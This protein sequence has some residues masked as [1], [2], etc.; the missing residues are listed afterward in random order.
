MSSKLK[1]WYVI[2]GLTLAGLAVCMLLLVVGGLAGGVAAYVATER[3][4]FF[5]PHWWQWQQI[6]PQ[7]PQAE[8]VPIPTPRVPETW[9][10]PPELMP[11]RL[12]GQLW[13]AAVMDI[14]ADGPADEAGLEAGDL[15]IGIDDK[16][17]DQERD[18][19]ALIGSYEPGDEVAVT[20]VRPGDDPELINLEVTLGSGT[21]EEG[22]E[23]ARLGL[24]Y[25]TVSSG[26]GV[27]FRGGMPWS[28]G[29]P[30]MD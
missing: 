14:D 24:E 26:L 15:I 12:S 3:G 17:M 28:G 2:L 21:N 1:K 19:R 25:R 22:E 23:V 20:V 29:V 16:A 9:Q 8:E 10:V 11:G 4:G 13:A 18:L 7:P 5:G 27:Y 6:Q 30:R